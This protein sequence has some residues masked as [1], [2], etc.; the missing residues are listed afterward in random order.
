M[1]RLYLL[2]H[3]EAAPAMGTGDK[4]RSLSTHGKVQ[5]IALGRSM[6]SKGY[7]P[8]KVYCS[9]ALRTRQ[10]LDGIEESFGS[11]NARY[12]DEIYY[13]GTGELFSFIQN[14]SDEKQSVLIVAHNPSIYELVVKLGADN[15]STH[16]QRLGMGYKPATLSVLDCPCEKWSDLQMYEN[17]LIDLLIADEYTA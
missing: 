6:M 5:A 13:G 14:T 10:T 11:L 1:K 4:D 2:R 7:K 15:P 17:A 16:L 8:E 3:A 12:E 9:G